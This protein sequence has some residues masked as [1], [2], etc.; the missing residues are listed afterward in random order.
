MAEMGLH[1]SARVDAAAVASLERHNGIRTEPQLVAAVF[2]DPAFRTAIA[3]A[4]DTR[5]IS[6]RVRT[7]F[8]HQRPRIRY[9]CGME[10]R[11][12]ELGDALIVYRERLRDR[13]VR[14]QAVLLQ[15]KVWAGMERG[16]VFTD[17]E[18]HALYRHWPPFRIEG[19]LP[20]NLAVGPGDYGRVLALD[21]RK[22][23]P[24][25]PRVSPRRPTEPGCT[26]DGGPW[27][28]TT[29]SLGRAIRGIVRFAVGER[30]EGDW[31]TAVLDM[32]RRVGHDS[33]GPSYPPGPRGGASGRSSE[34]PSQAA[35]R[36]NEDS[37][38]EI[39]RFFDGM[40]ALPPEDQAEFSDDDRP[41]SMMLI[42]SVEA[43]QK[44]PN[45]DSSVVV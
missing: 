10:E 17:P 45:V 6:I 3:D 23:Y 8:I 7:V 33:P 42:E 20:R 29:G 38:A 18:Q 43:N 1:G 32:I 13:Q 19:G 35:A 21:G 30:V 11:R 34:A 2:R 9:V 22:R 36:E 4:I 39:D 15:A 12:C 14:R 41:L 16:W 26:V 44:S 27:I 25:V 5:W 31:A 40:D 37:V 28:D 24:D